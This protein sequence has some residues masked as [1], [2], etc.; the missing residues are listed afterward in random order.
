MADTKS[1]RHAAASGSGTSGLT[2]LVQ[3]PE[4]LECKDFQEY[5][6]TRQTPET[7]E[8]LY[9][10]P[11]ICLAVYRE[12][13]ELARQFIIRILFVD[14]PV[15]QAVVTSWGAQRFAK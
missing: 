7:L 12:L 11:P 14:Q 15:P 2:P 1:G 5:L 8:K 4:N 10:Y 9:N 3:G 13:P 6:R